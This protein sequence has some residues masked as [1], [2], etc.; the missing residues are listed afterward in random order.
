MRRIRCVFCKVH[1]Q[2]LVDGLT[3]PAAKVSAVSFLGNITKELDFL[4]HHL[5]QQREKVVDIELLFPGNRRRNFLLHVL[6][7]LVEDMD[8][9]PLFLLLAIGEA[10]WVLME[11]FCL[12]RAVT[13]EKDIN[14]KPGTPFSARLRDIIIQLV[15]CYVG[16][17]FLRFELH[18]DTMW[19]FWIFT[20]V[21]ITIVPGLVMEKRGTRSGYSRFLH[22]CFICVA[23]I[24]FNPWCNMWVAIAPDFFSL[25]ANP[26]YYIMGVICL[27][28]AVRGLVLYEKLP[29]KSA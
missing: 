2:D 5:I 13:Y 26:W 23:L 28:F 6:H 15:C 1:L 3:E 14:W 8:H 27:F 12:Q 19:K 25:S 22:I 20:Q 16:L 17:N 4:V 7:K 21:L 9:F 11:I 29:E 10:V 18:D 24:S